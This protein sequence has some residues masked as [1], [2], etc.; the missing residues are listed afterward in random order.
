MADS[1]NQGGARA[2][3]PDDDTPP[4]LSLPVDTICLIIAKARELLGKDVSTDP[5]ASALD[6][7][8]IAAAVLEDRPSDP[9]ARELEALIGTLSEEAQIDLVTLMWLGRDEGDWNELRAIATSEHTDETVLYLAGT[10]LLADYLMAGLAAFGRD[11][12][13]FLAG[14]A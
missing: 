5:A 8:D 13:A 2:E 7:D 6:D 12:D 10:P 11:C 1:D 3:E 14:H 4:E 9:V